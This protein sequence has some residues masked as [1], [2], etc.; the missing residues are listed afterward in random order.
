MKGN[1]RSLF[2]KIREAQGLFAKQEFTRAFNILTEIEK[3]SNHPHLLAKIANYKV[4][5]LF[6]VGNVDSAVEYVERLLSCYPLSGQVNF[7]AASIY[8]K[9]GNQAR[10][11]RLYL[12]CVCL[13]P[14]NTQY[15]LVYA[16]FLKE[17]LRLTESVGI[18]RK[19]L[20]FNRRR[21]KNPDSGIYFLYLELGLNF[22]VMGCMKRALIL[23]TYCAQ[24]NTDFPF[25]DLIAEIH[26]QNRDFIRAHDN[27]QKHLDAWG[28]SDPD[29]LYIL[30]KIQSG[31]NLKNEALETLEKC[32]K[33]WGELVVTP[34]DMTYLFPLMQDGSLKNISN[35]VL[36]L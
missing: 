28:Q 2:A 14:S 6:Q 31:L 26:L 22:H 21:D 20:K 15:A 5:C 17:A 33:I 11:G 24:K 23:L 25:Y 34:G 36:E 27:I 16:Q 9:L 10:A 30:A 1:R 19:S 4:Q 3:N 12:R 29:A 7:L 32:C 18:I 13:Y 35:L 8:R